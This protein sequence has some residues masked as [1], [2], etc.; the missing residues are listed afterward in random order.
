MKKFRIDIKPT[1]ESDLSKRYLQIAEDSPQNAVRW[2]F[3]I[4]EAIESLEIL[5]LRCPLAPE[6]IDI[7]QD[8]RHLIIG[9]Y[10]ILYCV[11]D[12]RVEILHIRHSAM[13]RKL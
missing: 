11:I 12:N 2:Y 7:Q 5:A 3:N 9:D 1:A 13:Q 8:I 6:D 10:R 4:I